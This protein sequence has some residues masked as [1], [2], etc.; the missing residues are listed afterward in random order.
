MRWKLLFA[1]WIPPVALLLILGAAPRRPRAAN[2]PTTSVRRARL[3]AGPRAMVETCLEK[4]QPGDRVAPE[5]GGSPR[6]APG[7]SFLDVRRTTHMDPKQTLTDLAARLRKL[8][9]HAE[10]AKDMPAWKTQA[11][12]FYPDALDARGGRL[13]AEA[14]RAGAFAG[15]EYDSLHVEID[16][17]LED[18]KRTDD[19]KRRRAAYEAL[20]GV[21]ARWFKNRRGLPPLPEVTPCT[22]EAQMRHNAEVL[23]EALQQAADS[24]KTDAR[25]ERQGEGGLKLCDCGLG[26]SEDFTMVVWPKND[27]RFRLTARERDAFRKLHE[28]YLA[29]TPELGLDTLYDATGSAA[30]TQKGRDLFKTSG[31]WREG[32]V[33][34]GVRALTARL[35]P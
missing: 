23:A 1:A 31:I 16:P 28:A 14:M 8:P 29:G 32:L 15:M 18:A 9:D 7:Y 6:L 3:K 19:F 33:K 27:Q 11:H 22:V 10:D 17:I 21:A 2:H 24:V 35:D 34:P 25:E 12:R 20:F 5:K 4:S 30:N 26:H 13:L